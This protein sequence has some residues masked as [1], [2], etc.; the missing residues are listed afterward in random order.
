MSGGRQD[1]GRPAEPL[2][3][4]RVV[5]NAAARCLKSRLAYVT[6]SFKWDKM[7]HALFVQGGDTTKWCRVIAFHNCFFFLNGKAAKC[8]L[9]KPQIQNNRLYVQI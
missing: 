3:Y 7:N 2:W 9:P 8:S 5:L 4:E 1:T 6:S